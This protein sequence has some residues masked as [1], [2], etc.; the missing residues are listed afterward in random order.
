[1]A[2]RLSLYQATANAAP[3]R[4]RLE[5]DARVDVCIVGGGFTGLGAA[6]HLARAGRSVIVLESNSVGHGASGR[7]GGQAISGFRCSAVDLVARFGVDHAH[8]LNA[9]AM[10][11]RAHLFDLIA[12]AAIACD[13]RRGHLHVT[14]KQRGAEALKREADCLTQIMDE[15]GVRL[16]DR[17]AVGRQVA[18][19]GYIAGLLDPHGGHVHPLNLCLGLAE[20]TERAGARVCEQ[21]TVNAID[22]GTVVTRQGNVRAQHVIVA[23][24]S[25]ID[26]LLPH[27]GAVHMPVV[28]YQIATEPLDM[29]LIPERIAVSDTKFV[30]DYYRM[31]A[32]NRLIFGGGERYSPHEPV[33]PAA[34]VR[35]YM[36]KVFPQLA[37]AGIDYVWGGAV[38]ITRSRFPALGRRGGVFYAHGYSGLG[39]IW[40]PFVGKLMAEAVIGTQDRFDLLAALPRQRFPGG[41][42]LRHPL[43]VLGMLWYALQD[44]L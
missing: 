3:Q 22:G 13:V 28:N 34:F 20:A 38:S 8:R 27:Q 9:L 41:K 23:T 33:D 30:V 24:D 4:V 19:D 40:A 6:L 39:V 17:T 11:A 15:T 42:L 5:G 7:C 1:M 2:R 25:W 43:Y 21:T 18:S 37:Q 32:D 12:S 31:S 35:S 36:L 16:L 10:E 44:R 14:C 29:P 26:S